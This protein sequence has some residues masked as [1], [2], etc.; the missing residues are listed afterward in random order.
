M[1]S[2]HLIP[3]SPHALHTLSALDGPKQPHDMEDLRD[4]THY[5]FSHDNLADIQHIY[6]HLCKRRLR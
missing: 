2:T 1:K 6:N 5:R 4:R 3:D